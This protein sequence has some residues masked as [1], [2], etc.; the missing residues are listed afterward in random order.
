MA[1]HLG[2][3]Q[4]WM[5]GPNALIYSDVSAGGL[6]EVIER[7]NHEVSGRFWSFDGQLLPR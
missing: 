4:T 5:S 6:I 7:A 1:L 3:V 2:W